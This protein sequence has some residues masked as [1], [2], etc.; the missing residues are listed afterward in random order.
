MQKQERE[1]KKMSKERLNSILDEMEERRENYEERPRIPQYDG[2]RTEWASYI[3]ENLE[4]LY[5]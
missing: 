5:Q 4:N 3:T 1:V 2:F